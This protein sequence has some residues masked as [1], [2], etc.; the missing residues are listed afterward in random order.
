LLEK[1]LDKVP[2][3]QDRLSL[4]P[5]ELETLKRIQLRTGTGASASDVLLM[6][7][8][9]PTVQLG[10][11]LAGASVGPLHMLPYLFLEPEDR[12]VSMDFTIR[13]VLREITEED[14]GVGLTTVM[15]SRNADLFLPQATVAAMYLQR[16]R[17]T[18]FDAVILHVDD[19]NHVQEVGKEI[20]DM[21]LRED[22]LGEW[23]RR[24]R[25]STML[26]VYVTSFLAIVALIV[27]SIGITNTMIMSVMERRREIGIMKAVGAR[28]LHIEMMFLIE[29]ALIGVVGGALGI[30]LAWLLSMPG[31]SL[32]R[33]LL[34]EGNDVPLKGPLFIFPLWL[35]IG[36]PAFATLITTL[37][38]LYPARRAARVNPI[39][40][41]KDE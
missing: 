39:A 5:A 2:T 28:D 13:G 27:A 35:V 10:G 29:G 33:R 38:A 30:F 40:A 12:S 41:L 24:V 16:N 1:I 15:L 25:T 19:E 14:E 20:R 26:V 37:A 23:A 9:R 18:G 3:F 36:V 8:S 6:G 4:S 32:A 21:G 17:E 11:L 34:A 22:S 7:F 31:D